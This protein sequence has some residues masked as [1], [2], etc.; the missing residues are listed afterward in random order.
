MSRTV[1][2]PGDRQGHL[3]VLRAVF[4][5]L[6]E[7]ETPGGVVH[8]PFEWHETPREAASHPQEPS[9]IALHLRKHFRDA[10]RFNN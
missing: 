8:L 5:A 9:P 7:I 2:R 6:Q 4:Q 3:A 1:G 10:P